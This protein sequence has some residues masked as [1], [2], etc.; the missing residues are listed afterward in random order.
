VVDEWAAIHKQHWEPT[1]RQEMRLGLCRALS[2]AGHD[3]TTQAAKQ[4]LRLEAVGQSVSDGKQ[5]PNG[6]PVGRPFGTWGE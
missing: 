6:Q 2:R 3:R 4:P 5:P 1:D